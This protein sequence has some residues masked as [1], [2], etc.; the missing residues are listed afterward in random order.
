LTRATWTS[1]MTDA[2]S[3]RVETAATKPTNKKS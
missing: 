2:R 3:I 1:T